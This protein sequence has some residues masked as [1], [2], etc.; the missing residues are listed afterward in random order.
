MATRTM[1]P[2][3]GKRIRI[4]QLDN[5]GRVPAAGTED[6]FIVTDGF[7]S[8]QLSSTTEEGPEITQR[9]I[10][11]A[12]VINEKLSDSF[13]RFTMELT[14]TGVNPALLP[15]VSNAKARQNADGDNTGFTIGEGTIEKWFAFELWTGLAGTACQEGEEDASGYML[16]PF[17]QAGTLG[18]VTV[19]GENAVN[20]AMTGAY[21]RGGHAWG[22]GPYQVEYGAADEP[23]VLVEPLDPFDH[24]YFGFTGLTPPPMADDPQPMVDEGGVS[25]TTT[26][27]V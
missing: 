17:V 11:G 25:T 13:K 8:V 22:A 24:F 14:F 3:R 15:M 1:K 4:T 20:F 23:S 9:G 2:V 5:C 27:Q 16:L 18:D 21:T 26:T 19:D 7:V 6:A 10:T 12:I